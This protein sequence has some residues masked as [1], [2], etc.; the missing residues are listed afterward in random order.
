MEEITIE[1]GEIT[2]I[3]T[4]LTEREQATQS[5]ILMAGSI[6]SLSEW[7]GKETGN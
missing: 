2:Q 6:K 3:G 7:L 4:K 1:E 5:E